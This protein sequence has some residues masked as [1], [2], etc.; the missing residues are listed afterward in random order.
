MRNEVFDVIGKNLSNLRIDTV[1]VNKRKVGPALYPIEKFYPRML[2]YLLRYVIG[3]VKKDGAAEVIVITD[4]IP[5]KKKRKTVVKAV[6]VTLSEMLTK[7]MSYRILHHSSRSNIGLQIADYCNWAIFRKWSSDDY[8]SYNLIRKAI[9][10]EF[11]IFGVGKRLY[12]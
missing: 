9:R 6:K 7:D 3:V 5:I 4:Q 8:R 12:Y 10:S 11:D 1:L 2:G